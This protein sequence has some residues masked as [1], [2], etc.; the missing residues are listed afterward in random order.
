[1][2]IPLATTIRHIFVETGN[3]GITGQTEVPGDTVEYLTPYLELALYTSNPVDVDDSGFW[4]RARETEDLL[5]V[6][7]GHRDIGA[8]TISEMTVRPPQQDDEPATLQISLAAVEDAIANK[9]FDPDR[10]E[11]I[12]D[13][14]ADLEMCIAWTWLELRG[15]ASRDEEELFN[16]VEALMSMDTGGMVCTVSENA[17]E[18]PQLVFLIRDDPAQLATIPEDPPILV[19][20][21]LF[22]V[23]DVLLVPLVV[24]LGDNWYGTGFIA[25][26]GENQGLEALELLARDDHLLF[27]LYDGTSLEP[28]RV[29]QFDNS[30]TDGAADILR[31]FE[32]TPNWSMEAFDAAQEKLFE[33]FPNPQAI[34]E[35]GS[36]LA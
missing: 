16:P 12:I 2:T 11:D 26:A 8:D 23:D 22:N 10:D 6:S 21:T 13:A 18:Q 20:V 19:Q 31:A 32:N 25:W 24:N 29:I 34:F 33:R 9:A 30:L 7:I 35:H 15:F 28:I 1:M 5:R 4:I 27:Y 36:D 17:G 14:V 3:V